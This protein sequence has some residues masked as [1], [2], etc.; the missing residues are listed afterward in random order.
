MYSLYYRLYTRIKRWA[1]VDKTTKEMMYRFKGM[2]C[3]NTTATP[4]AN[5]RI[6]S[7]AC[8][9]GT[10]DLLGQNVGQVTAHAHST[11]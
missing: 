1:S 4:V 2:H 3:S 10:V 6:G 9:L 8:V 11:C 7:T 5:W